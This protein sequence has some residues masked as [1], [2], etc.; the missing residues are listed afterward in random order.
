MDIK[1]ISRK[2][3]VGRIGKGA[4]LTFLASILPYKILA[5][6]KPEKKIDVKIHPSAVKRNNKV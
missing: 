4:F 5:S 2:I 6:Q 1:K 3:F